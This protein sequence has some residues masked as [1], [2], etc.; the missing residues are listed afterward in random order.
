MRRWIVSFFF[1]R[2]TILAF[3]E[4]IF[5]QVKRKLIAMWERIGKALK[6]VYST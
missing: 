1:K 4:N 2:K 3:D 5:P 6:M